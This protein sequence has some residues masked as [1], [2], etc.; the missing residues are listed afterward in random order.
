MADFTASPIGYAQGYA[1]I[2]IA[3]LLE[4]NYTLV[5]DSIILL[6]M[7]DKGGDYGKRWKLV[8][9]SSL[10]SQVGTLSASLNSLSNTVSSHTTSITNLSSVQSSQ[11]VSINN[12]T[13]NLNTLGNAI[14]SLSTSVGQKASKTPQPAQIFGVTTGL[15]YTSVH[16][17][18]DSASLESNSPLQFRKNDMGMVVLMGRFEGKG[19]NPGGVELM[20]TLPSGYRP[21]PKGINTL[22]YNLTT[23]TL[24]SIII[25]P[26]GYIY[27][28]GAPTNTTDKFSLVAPITFYGS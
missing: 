12:L 9:S 5:P 11:G 13:T 25:E 1:G 7:I 10:I 21:S 15:V 16:W 26:T 19:T 6:Q 3:T 28:V 2:E 23:L 24:Y 22:A 27:I 4:A 20:A 14:D 8:A 17:Q 18:A